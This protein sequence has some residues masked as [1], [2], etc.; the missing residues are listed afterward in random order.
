M[1]TLML[2]HALLVVVV[3][4]AAITDAR[5]GHI[6]NWITL[7]GIVLGI[8][9]HLGTS[10]VM[11]LVLSIAATSACAL[12]PYI[13][14]RRD[15]MGGGDVKLLAA[16]GA[17]AGPT[18]GMEV[19]LATFVAAAI[20]VL[21]RMS[22]RGKLLATLGRTFQLAFRTLARRPIEERELDPELDDAV[23]LGLPALAA[24]LFCLITRDLSPWS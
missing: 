22:Y 14:F 2:T 13:L 3:A 21:A 1:D 23:R 20:F 18:L 4:L 7:P 10:G 15:A 9:L 16:V 11:G 12:V 5:T 17:I 19:Q 6:P 8:A 24:T